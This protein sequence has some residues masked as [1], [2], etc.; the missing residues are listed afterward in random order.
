VP[1]NLAVEK[2]AQRPW[3]VTDDDIRQVREAGYSEDQIYELVQ[4]AAAGAGVRRLA[5]GLHA[6]EDAE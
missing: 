6:I 2:I 4:A 3:T 5:A 1:E